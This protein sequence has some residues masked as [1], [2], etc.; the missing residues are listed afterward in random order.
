VPARRASSR[1][2]RP[3]RRRALR[4]STAA[5]MPVDGIR[6]DTTCDAVR[7]RRPGRR[8]PIHKIACPWQSS[9]PSWYART[10]A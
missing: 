1:N 6:S 3:A 4:S 10:T 5:F 8:R 7:R 2:V 9:R